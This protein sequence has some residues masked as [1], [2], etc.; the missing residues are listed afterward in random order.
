MVIVFWEL[1]R[2]FVVCWFVE[3]VCEVIGFEVV[4]VI[5]DVCF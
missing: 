3:L 4:V 1:Y 2:W 5:G